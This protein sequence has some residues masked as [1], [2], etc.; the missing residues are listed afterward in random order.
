MFKVHGGDNPFQESGVPDLLCCYRGYFFGLEAKLPGK[1]LDPKQQAVS[2]R[3]IKAG[4][5]AARFESVKDLEEILERIL[6]K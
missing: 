5:I 4:G 6:R 2:A 1:K 3:I